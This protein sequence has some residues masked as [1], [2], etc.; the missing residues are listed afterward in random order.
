[1]FFKN[2]ETLA[3]YYLMKNLRKNN[4]ITGPAM[5]YDDHS[6]IMVSPNWKA[7]VIEK[8]TI[9]LIKKTKKEQRQ[10]IGTNVDPIKLEIFNI[11]ENKSLVL[12]IPCEVILSCPLK[13][14]IKI[15]CTL[16][17]SPSK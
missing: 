13:F 3:K 11:S 7:N 2:S 9:F 5:I 14:F 15:F 10:Y 17:P 12:N 6:T 8:D 1:M 16:C 4:Y